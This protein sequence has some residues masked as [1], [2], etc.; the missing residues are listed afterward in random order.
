MPL[1][2]TMN[3]GRTKS[4]KVKELL[5]HWDV[6][7]IKFS[8]VPVKNKPKSSF[9]SLGLQFLTPQTC[10]VACLSSH[11]PFGR[12]VARPCED[13]FCLLLTKPLRWSGT[14]TQL[15]THHSFQ[16]QSTPSKALGGWRNFL[17]TPL[18][19]SSDTRG[20]IADLFHNWW[21][22]QISDEI[23]P[24]TPPLMWAAELLKSSRKEMVSDRRK[25]YGLSYSISPL[26]GF[27]CG[28][29]ND[30][31]HSWFLSDIRLIEHPAALIEPLPPDL[32]IPTI[33]CEIPIRGLVGSDG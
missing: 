32:S 28:H 22:D 14:V 23:L 3:W 30:Y 26:T 18:P 17:G 2:M 8:T 13:S 21:F 19:T 31:K 1:Q 33:K 24:C 5:S 9:F 12:L 16:G 6:L 4:T 29:R 11:S 20:S 27:E 7:K 25:Q 15:D 10:S